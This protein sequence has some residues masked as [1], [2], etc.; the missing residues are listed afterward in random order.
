[1]N[2]I[3]KASLYVGLILGI[4]GNLFVSLLFRWMDDKRNLEKFFCLIIIFS[5]VLFLVGYLG[6][7]YWLSFL[8]IILTFLIALLVGII[9][10]YHFN[11]GDFKK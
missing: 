9:I 4:L 3:D 2:N 6:Q 7:M 1:M 10:L 5:M 8:I 11:P